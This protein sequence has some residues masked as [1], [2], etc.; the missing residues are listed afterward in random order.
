MHQKKLAWRRRN[1]LKP[2]HQFASAG[3]RR[4]LPQ[5][6]DFGLYRHALPVNLDRLRSFL[7]RAATGSLCLKAGQQYA[8]ARIGQALLEVMQD[9]AASSHAARRNN[10]RR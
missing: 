2:A 4:K 9:A 5:V 7:E 3:V 10:D 6:Y 8:I 1:S